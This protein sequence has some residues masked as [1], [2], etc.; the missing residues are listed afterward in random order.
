VWL[1]C[2][3]LEAGA[4]KFGRLDVRVPSQR[5][6]DA[7][8]LKW[9]KDVWQKHNDGR[10]AELPWKGM[11]LTTEVSRAKRILNLE[12]GP[13]HFDL[14]LYAV[15]IGKAVAFGG[16]PGEPFNDIGKAVKRNSPFTLT[17]P[18]CLVNGAR[19]YFPFSDAYEGGGYESAA[20]PFGPTVADDLIKGQG[21]LLERLYR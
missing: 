6:K 17:V 10:D 14:P 9:A 13:D 12:K 2:I 1:K 18:A 5:A 3:P 7:K 19:G 20:S 4:V 21:A 11:E 8:E 16:F 15:A